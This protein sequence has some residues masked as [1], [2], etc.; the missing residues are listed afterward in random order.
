MNTMI[1]RIAVGVAA[2]G[3]S[4]PALAS[5]PTPAAP[6]QKPAVTAK[7]QKHKKAHRK[8]AQ[9]PKADEKKA[10]AKPA[11]KPVEKTPATTPAAPAKK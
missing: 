3:L 8:V 1:R 10:E 4:L 11:S 7:V 5:S 9:A 2:L 6:E